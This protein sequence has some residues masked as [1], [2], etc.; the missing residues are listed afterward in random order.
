MENHSVLVIGAAPAGLT[1]AYELVKKGIQPIVLEQADKVGGISRTETYKG[2]HFDIGGHRFFTKV[3]EVQQLWNEVLGDEFIKTPRLSRIYYQGKFFQYPL[4]VF[5]TLHKLGISESLLILLSYLKI[6]QR[7]LTVEENLEQWVTNRFGARLYKTFFKTYTEKVW[8]IPCNQIQAEWAAQRIKGLSV[9][10]AVIN[11][12][13]GSNDTKTLIKEFDY[14]VLGPGM[15][16]QRFAEKVEAGGGE[17]RLNTRVLGLEHNCRRITKVTAQHDGKLVQFEA[18]NLISSMPLAIL[19]NRLNPPPPTKVLQAANQLKYRDFLIVS[20]IVDAPELFPDNWIYIHSPE[21]KVGRIQNFKNWSPKMVPDSSKTCLGMEYFCNVGESLWEMSNTELINLAT[22]E[23]DSLGL[24]NGAVVED[25]VVIRQPKAYPVYD[26][27]YRQHLKVIQNYLQTFEN[28]Q[29]TGRNG[30]HR[31][32]NQ[33]HSMLTGLLAAKNI[34]GEN[35]DLWEV[36][37][38]RSYY[39]EFTTKQ[40]KDDGLLVK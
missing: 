29:T 36:N 8:G 12:F 19:I 38:E 2:Y 7:P 34:L 32:N 17:V 28:L 31:Y 9:K 4:S 21:V 24:A 20:L 37:T 14:P 16:W 3:A 6:K 23:L 18:E 39:E 30:M 33:D 25:G 22:K 11:A 35:H 27:E 40:N 26:H 10:K 15:M 13:F 5:D 1:A